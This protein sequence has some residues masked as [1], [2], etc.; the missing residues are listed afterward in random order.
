V[1]VGVA[2]AGEDLYEAENVEQM[3]SWKAWL[4]LV[5]TVAALLFEVRKTFSKTRL[6]R[7]KALRTMSCDI[8]HKSSH[9]ANQFPRN[10]AITNFR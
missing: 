10:R 5:F 1:E 6:M 4:C 7:A 8:T 2:G 3:F 9:K